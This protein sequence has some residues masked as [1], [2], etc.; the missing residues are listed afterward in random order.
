MAFSLFPVETLFNK[1]V[2]QLRELARR[3]GDCQER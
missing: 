2:V 1:M 3:L